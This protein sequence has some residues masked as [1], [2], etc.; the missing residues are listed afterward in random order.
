MAR[1]DT[2]SD[3]SL[4]ASSSAATI[5]DEDFALTGKTIEHD[6]RSVENRLE[7]P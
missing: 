2:F 3:L 5:P 4:G 6:I 1:H 7:S